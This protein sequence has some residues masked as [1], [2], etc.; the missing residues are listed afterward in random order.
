M[1]FVQL[2]DTDYLFI[3]TTVDKNIDPDLLNPH[4]I[5]A[6]DT[7]I[8]QIIG[9]NLYQTLMSMVST[10]DIDLPQYSQYRILLANF[11]QP[12]LAHWAVWHSLP[13]IQYRLTNKS[14]LSK[15]T[16]SANTTGLEELKYLR[17]NIRN[18]AEYYNQ[19]IREQ[20]INSPADYPE[21]WQTVGI[22]RIR[23]KRTT[24]FSGWSGNARQPQKVN[25]RGRGDDDCCDEPFG[26][27][28]NW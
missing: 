18:Y 12:A 4:I 16:D 11:I 19:R 14:I 1:S 6:Q 9:Y 2:I 23:P 27:L 15:T 17:D 24:Y 21:Y 13:S 22:D 7:N 25:K 5:V 10:G 20:I 26:T 8:V 28:L 3:H